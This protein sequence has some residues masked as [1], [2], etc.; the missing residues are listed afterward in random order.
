MDVDAVASGVF[1]TVE[2]LDPQP[3]RST[4]AATIAARLRPRFGSDITEWH[5]T[6]LGV[7]P[8]FGRAASKWPQNP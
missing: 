8:W 7:D 6:C 1:E 3:A 2:S 4:A 5:R